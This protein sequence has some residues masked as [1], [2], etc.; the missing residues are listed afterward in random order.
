MRVGPGSSPARADPDR[1]L[2]RVDPAAAI[3]PTRGPA[4]DDAAWQALRRRAVLWSIGVATVLA[5]AKLVA[6]LL[7]GS[8][9]VLSSLADSLADMAASGLALWSV[10]VAHRPADEEHRFG[11]GKAEALTSLVQAAFVGTSGVFVLYTGV[12]RVLDP[13]PLEHT[14]LAVAVMVLSIIGSGVVVAI[15][16]RVLRQVKSVAI[17]ADSLHY[18]SDLLA[19]GA[20]V[21]AILLTGVDGMLWVDPVVGA[22]IAIYLFSAAASI[23]RGSVDLLMDKELPQEHR[24]RI[25]RIVA[26][27]PDARGVHDLRTRSLGQAAHVELH[28][29]LD[30]RM[31][32]YRAHA[33]CERVGA[34]IEAEFPGSEITIHTDPAGLEEDRLDDRIAEVETG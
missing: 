2:V 25:E 22:I 32:L 13:R 17:E 29:E 26:S 3:D 23:V 19:N 7:S 4:P 6:A 16:S 10:T 1:I 27:D 20:V 11:H 18:R 31:D 30:G 34:A 24:D 9:S 28:L 12:T 14:T 15:Q 5:G 21:L 33:I 8:V